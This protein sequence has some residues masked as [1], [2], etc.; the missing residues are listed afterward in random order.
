[1]ENTSKNFN[2]KFGRPYYTCDPN[3]ILI[4]R[5]MLAFVLPLLMDNLLVGHV[6]FWDRNLI[7][8]TQLY[9]IL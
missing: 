3:N 6:E 8:S 5:Q 9:G 2:F 4:E 1:M 7:I